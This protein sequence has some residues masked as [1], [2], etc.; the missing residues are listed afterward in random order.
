MDDARRP[1]YPRDMITIRP[2]DSAADVAA[3]RQLLLEYAAALP[4]D[5]SFQDFQTEIATLP[6][7][8]APPA[9][10]LL[11][12]EQSGQVVGCVAL[13]PL[14]PPVIAELK[15]LYVR[16]EARGE[17]TGLALTDAVIDRA[18]QA[19]YL[20]IRLDTLPS[21]RQAQNLYRAMGFVE[22]PPYRHNPVPGTVFMELDLRY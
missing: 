3:V 12:A 8:Y 20:Q 21:M 19:G 15:R 10:A 9:G 14:V 2:S 13:R 11:L 17:G 5:L 4:V 6:G 7:A 18:R 16:P 22:I 1:E